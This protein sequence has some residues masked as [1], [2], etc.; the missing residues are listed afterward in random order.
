MAWYGR[1]ALKVP[2]NPNQPTNQPF[3]FSI[4]GLFWQALLHIMESTICLPN[5]NLWCLLM[6]DSLHARCTSCPQTQCQSTIW[7]CAIRYCRAICVHLACQ[8]LLRSSVMHVSVKPRLDV[9]PESRYDNQFYLW[10]ADTCEMCRPSLVWFILLYWL[11]V[12][13]TRRVQNLTQGSRILIVAPIL[14]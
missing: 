3:G 14:Q 11:T 9:M 13:V 2:L 5:K 8:E 12:I 1:F 10:F 4:T 6:W 7:I